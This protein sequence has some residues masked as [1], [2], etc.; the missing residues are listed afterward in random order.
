MTGTPNRP[1]GETARDKS[2]SDAAGG[3]APPNFM[4]VNLK[5]I[6]EA[7]IIT[8]EPR[9]ILLDTLRALREFKVSKIAKIAL[10]RPSE[11]E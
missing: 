8:V 7:R 1:F 9:T 10:A 4:P 11:C 2:P 5:V 3:Q 6:G